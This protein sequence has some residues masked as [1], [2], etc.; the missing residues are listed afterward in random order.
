MFSLQVLA[1]AGRL[2]KQSNMITYKRII[3]LPYN[4][5]ILYNNDNNN[6]I[7]VYVYMYVCVC[8]YIYI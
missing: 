7:Y 1:G 4:N 8:I 2:I 3:I 6:Y 5:I